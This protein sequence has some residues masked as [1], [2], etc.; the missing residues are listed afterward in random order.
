MFALAIL[1]LD[2]RRRQGGIAALLFATHYLT[3][4]RLM[5]AIFVPLLLWLL[6]QLNAVI[7]VLTGEAI[8]LVY[9]LLF[10]GFSAYFYLADIRVCGHSRLISLMQAILMGFSTISS[11]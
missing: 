6:M 9:S 5:Q 11:P 3:F 8:E 4:M 10:F 2:F 7:P 1:L